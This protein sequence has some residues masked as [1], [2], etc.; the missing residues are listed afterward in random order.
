MPSPRRAWLGG[1]TAQPG[2]WKAPGRAPTA[3]AGSAPGAPDFSP[4]P[5]S[6]A[7]VSREDEGGQFRRKRK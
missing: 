2:R 6:P 4:T 3:P 1:D 7:P 5:C